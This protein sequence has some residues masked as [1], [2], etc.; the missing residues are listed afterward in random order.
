[1]IVHTASTN[2]KGF[3]LVSS[4]LLTKSGEKQQL[5][6]SLPRT[7]QLNL[8]NGMVQPAGATVQFEREIYGSSSPPAG[9]TVQFERVVAE[10]HHE[11]IHGSS[12]QPAAANSSSQPSTTERCTRDSR[13]VAEI[14]Q[15]A[16]IEMVDMVEASDSAVV[17]MSD[18]SDMKEVC[19]APSQHLW[20]GIANDQPDMKVDLPPEN[21]IGLDKNTWWKEHGVTIG[22]GIYVAVSAIWIRILASMDCS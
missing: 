1:M 6:P 12:S 3:G 8:L 18:I 13:R 19:Q 11:E 17:E 7:T 14:S 20:D 5:L 10:V 22:V 16:V 4:F 9:A 15:S 2:G 21:V